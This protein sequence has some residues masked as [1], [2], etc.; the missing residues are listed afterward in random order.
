M[1]GRTTKLGGVFGVTLLA[2]GA[3]SATGC[4]GDDNGDSD[5]GGLPGFGNKLA[6]QCG[7]TCPK[8]GQG[9][10]YGNASITGYAPIDGFFRSVVNYGTVSAGVSAEIDAELAGI[11]SLFEISPAE[12]TA[13]GNLGAAITAKLAGTYKASVVV[14][15]TPAKCSVDAGLTVK[16]TVD[17]QAQAG[18]EVDRGKLAVNCMG[19]CNVD[20]D[21][22]GKC[23]ADATVRCNVSGPELS[24]MG[25]CSGSCTVEAPTVNCQGSC[26]GTCDGACSVA[27]DAGGKCNGTCTGTCTGGCEVSGQAAVSCAGKCSGS[28]E[29]TPA[30]A[31][32]EANAKVTCDVSATAKA[33]CTGRCEGEFEPPKV[34]CDASASCE[35]SAK[36]EARF[37]VQCTPPKVEV[38]IVAQAGGMAQA[39]VDFLIAELQARLPRLSAA[40]ARADLAAK[41]G[42]ELGNAGM[43]AVDSTV[44]AIGD[45]EVDFIVGAKITA[46]TPKQLVESQTLITQASAQIKTRTDNASAVAKAFGM[47]ML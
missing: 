2:L 38:K 5:G 7:L 21:A 44:N 4:P 17:C 11:Q 8:D 18:C 13:S 15:T 16:A 19:T 27:L 46:C 12:L 22:Q 45:G 24:C 33:S 31:S 30:M 35:A 1:N 41:A 20:V 26:T 9:V 47:I 28:C 10:L 34:N 14:N 39:R 43:N 23:A 36:A 25:E 29:Y 3:L 6:E 42:A 40:A 32:C 37:Q